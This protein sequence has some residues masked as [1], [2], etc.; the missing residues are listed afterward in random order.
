[1]NKN[2]FINYLKDLDILIDDKTLELLQIY[3]DY[4]LEYNKTTN[5][6]AIKDENSV[7]LKHFY[8]SLTINKYLE[9]N[10]NLLDIGTGAGFPGMVIAIIRPDIQVTLLDSNNKKIK[11]LENLLDK[12]KINNVT[13]VHNRA[14]V[15]AKEN[16]ENFDIV[17]SRAVASLRVLCELALP[18]LK[19]D[20]KFIAMKGMLDTELDEALDTIEILN[21][22]IIKR[23]KFILPIENSNR[24]NLIIKK[25][26]SCNSLYPR[27][28]DKIIKKPLVKK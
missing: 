9:S 12:L 17:T 2:E 6:T 19:I 13:L 15:F 18:M 28:Y 5:L 1:M 20:G 22:S 23:D 24:E 14:E 7:Y 25:I 26:K 27:D 21:G 3:C 16:I 8:D 11:F 10:I 4:L